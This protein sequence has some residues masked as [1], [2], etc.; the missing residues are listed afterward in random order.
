[1]RRCLT[2]ILTLIASLCTT[3][4][5]AASTRAEDSAPKTSIDGWA[6]WD[7]GSSLA[8][9]G[10]SFYSLFSGPESEDF[11]GIALNEYS[12]AYQMALDSG[13]FTPEL[14]LCYGADNTLQ[15][16]LFT[17]TADYSP[18]DDA[19]AQALAWELHDTIAGNYDAALKVFDSYPGGADR[20]PE[21][22][23]SSG[24][25]V[26]ADAAGNSIWLDWKG[27]N[28]GILY[29]TQGVGDA[30]IQSF[31]DDDGEAARAEGQTGI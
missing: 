1:M 13:S 18:L 21:D 2:T 9:P 14:R 31:D 11:S 16:V 22:P 29:A 23:E 28:L 15:A 17:F 24:T 8:A 26:L 7:F 19:T 5:L 20:L 27:Q 12:T 10:D 6:Y 30:L 25:L 3:F 4:A